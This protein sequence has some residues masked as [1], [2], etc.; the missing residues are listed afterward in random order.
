[1]DKPVVHLALLST[2]HE[3]MEG[4]TASLRTLFE[5]TITRI[6]H[7][8]WGVDNP[9]PTVRHQT[10]N[11]FHGDYEPGDKGAINIHMDFPR[12]MEREVSLFQEL[13]T[14]TVLNREYGDQDANKTF[15]LA[16]FEVVPAGKNSF[17]LG[18]IKLITNVCFPVVGVGFGKLGEDFKHRHRAFGAEV[19]VDWKSIPEQPVIIHEAEE[20]NSSVTISGIELIANAKARAKIADLAQV[21]VQNLSGTE[22][23]AKAVAKK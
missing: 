14:N 4:Y 6:G 5:K 9:K 1:M 10:H 3:D 16:L 7:F 8:H 21:I 19:P 20:G 17:T 15:T 2:D 12:S 11:G 23:K 13:F 18:R 22:P